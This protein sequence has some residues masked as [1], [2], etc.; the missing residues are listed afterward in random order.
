MIV[1]IL[2]KGDDDKTIMDVVDSVVA[3]LKKSGIRT[4]VD[5]RDNYNPGFK[6]NHWE[7]RGVPLRIE[8]GKRDVEKGE[9]MVVRRFDGKK[10]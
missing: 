4:H 9:V 6:F 3:T 7:L 2:N 5:D 1:P 8:V 10:S